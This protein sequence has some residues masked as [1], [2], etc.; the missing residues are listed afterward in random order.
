MKK[1]AAEVIYFFLAALICWGLVS[2]YWSKNPTKS[3]AQF[4]KE[5]C[6]EEDNVEAFISTPGYLEC[7]CK[8]GDT[9]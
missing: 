3:P 6:V 8:L 5:Y 7:H 9:P 4:C 1:T 2:L